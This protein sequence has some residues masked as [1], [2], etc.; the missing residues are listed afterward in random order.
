MERCNVD[1]NGNGD[2]RLKVL[3]T[4]TWVEKSLPEDGAT[5]G[6]ELSRHAALAAI[7]GGLSPLGPMPTP[8]SAIRGKVSICGGKENEVLASCP[9]CKTFETLWFKGNV[10][11]PTKRFAQGLNKRVY[12]DCGSDEPCRLFPKFPA[13]W[14]VTGTSKSLPLYLIETSQPRAETNVCLA[15]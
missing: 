13:E 6:G 12:H 7:L 3:Q 11:S 8:R 10:L 15:H 5:S 4:I 9:K 14:S 1:S 2:G